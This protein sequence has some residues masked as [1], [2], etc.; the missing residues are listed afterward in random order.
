MIEILTWFS[1]LSFLA[2]GTACLATEHMRKEFERFGLAQQRVLIGILQLAG[3]LGLLAGFFLPWVGSV[4]AAGLA[5]QM[6]IGVGVRMKVGD[7]LLQTA[8]AGV[9][10]VLNSYLFFAPFLPV[11]AKT[12]G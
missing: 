10:L 1:A 5:L 7:S 12:G 3:A 8:Q 9:Y 4:A 2:Y 6:L 11:L